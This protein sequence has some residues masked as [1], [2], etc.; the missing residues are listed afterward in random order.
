MTWSKVV[1]KKSDEPCYGC[2]CLP[3]CLQKKTS[4]DLLTQCSIFYK[5][6]IEESGIFKKDVPEEVEIVKCVYISS[7]FTPLMLIRHRDQTPKDGIQAFFYDK[8]YS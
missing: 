7:H 5:H 3:V 1:T 8:E 4:F 6:I 2:F